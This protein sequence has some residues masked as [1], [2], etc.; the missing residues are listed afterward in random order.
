MTN[1]GSASLEP[2]FTQA[3][4]QDADAQAHY[5]MHPTPGLVCSDRREG[6][7]ISCFDPSATQTVPT[8]CV[9][10]S[11]MAVWGSPFRTLPVS[12]CVHEG[13]RRQPYPVTGSGRQD[14]QLPRRLAYPSPIQRAVGRLQALGA[15]APQPIGASGQLGKEQALPCADNLFSRCGVRLGEYDGTPHR[16]TCPISAERPEFLQRQEC[17]TTETV[18]EAPGA[19]GIRSCS[20]AARIASYETTSAAGSRGGHGA[21]VHCEWVSPSSVAAPSAPGRTLPFY[22]PG[23]P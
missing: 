10:R 18:S 17:G 5:Q 11:G 8:V 1:P 9:R 19:Y 12:P 2:D 21:A 3:S 14:P 15:T 23:C 4:I 6:C 13:R 20:H 16:G 7:L 22:G